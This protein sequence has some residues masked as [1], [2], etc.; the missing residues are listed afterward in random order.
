MGRPLLPRQQAGAAA[1]EHV[2]GADTRPTQ[3][4]RAATAGWGNR[5]FLDALCHGKKGEVLRLPCSPQTLP[6]QQQKGGRGGE[7]LLL[8]AAGKSLLD[9]GI[10]GDPKFEEFFKSSSPRS[11]C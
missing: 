5:T 6:L 9:P 4:S 11:I 7:R 2:L 8:L 1:T 10:Q 3:S